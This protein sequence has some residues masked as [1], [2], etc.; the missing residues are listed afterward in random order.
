MGVGIARWVGRGSCHRCVDKIA[1]DQWLAFVILGVLGA[2]MVFMATRD[3]KDQL[4]RLRRSAGVLVL[5]AIAS[6]L[7]ALAVGVT[8]T[9]IHVNIVAQATAI[10]LATFIITTV[11]AV[12]SRWLGPICGRVVEIL[13]GSCLIGIGTKILIEHSFC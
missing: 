7:D 3:S 11:G 5:T 6:S 4:P 12:A 8:M 9:F 1:I 10:G 2:R 13:G